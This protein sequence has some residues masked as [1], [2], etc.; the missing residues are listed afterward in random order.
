MQVNDAAF[1]ACLSLLPESL[2]G[3]VQT[4]FGTRSERWEEIRLR[5]GRGLSLA[6]ERGEQ[7]IS[8]PGTVDERDLRAVLERATRA[9]YQSAA[10]QLSR[11][12]YTLKGGF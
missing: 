7:M 5:T 6:D 10:E 11:G 4:A 12:F 9:S 3:A 8:I 1:S 2:R